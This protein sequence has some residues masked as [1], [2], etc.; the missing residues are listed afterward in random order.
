MQVLEIL[1]FWISA[2]M[3]LTGSH[4]EI[5]NILFS[6]NNTKLVDIESD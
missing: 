2:L 5:E 1:E 6:S 3:S 4:G